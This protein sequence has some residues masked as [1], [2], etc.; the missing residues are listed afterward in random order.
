MLRLGRGHARPSLQ[1]KFQLAFRIRLRS[2]NDEC[3][4]GSGKPRHVKF[5]PCLTIGCGLRR[6]FR[7]V[8][9]TIDARGYQRASNSFSILLFPDGNMQIRALPCQPAFRVNQFQRELRSGRCIGM[10]RGILQLRC[11]DF[12]DRHG[13]RNEV[14]CAAANI[15]GHGAMLIVN[16]FSERF[17]A[18]RVQR[19]Q[20]NIVICAAMQN[21]AAAIDRS[22]DQSVRCAS[23]FGLDV[24]DRLS[25]FHIRV[26]PKEH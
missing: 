9:R 18:C 6:K 8:R 16:A 13:R 5:Q 1:L 25:H 7:D 11:R 12:F 17:F 20:I 3:G 26:M 24:I 22:I 4:L 14:Q 2:L 10:R 23:I 15:F 19:K 21:A